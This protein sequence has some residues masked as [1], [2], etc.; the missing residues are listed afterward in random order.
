MH[1]PARKCKNNAV[2]NKNIV[3]NCCIAF[4]CPI[5][6]V[7]IKGHTSNFKI[8]PRKVLNIDQ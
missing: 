5:L 2:F 8:S 1:E 4:K 6:A 7:S 3:K